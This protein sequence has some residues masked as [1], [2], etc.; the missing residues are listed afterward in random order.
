MRLR[1]YAPNPGTVSENK[2]FLKLWKESEIKS[3]QISPVLKGGS[4]DTIK[5]RWDGF[6]SHRRED[7]RNSLE[8]GLNG[9]EAIRRVALSLTKCHPASA[10]RRL[11]QF[12]NHYVFER[13]QGKLNG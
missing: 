7:E 12:F 2:T 11:L 1:V 10:H 5:N 4:A 13:I 6:P 3:W 8:D 9:L